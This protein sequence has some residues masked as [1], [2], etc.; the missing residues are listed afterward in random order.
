MAGSPGSALGLVWAI[1]VCKRCSERGYA[2]L[3]QVYREASRKGAQHLNNRVFKDVPSG[4]LS[5][6]PTRTQG[7]DFKTPSAGMLL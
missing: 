1:F 7:L 2:P 5:S 6:Q 4:L 3:P